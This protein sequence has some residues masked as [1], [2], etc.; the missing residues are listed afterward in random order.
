MAKTGSSAVASRL[1]W[2]RQD[3]HQIGRM[4]G[5]GSPTHRPAMSRLRCR[6]TSRFAGVTSG[7]TRHPADRQDRAARSRHCLRERSLVTTDYPGRIPH[8]AS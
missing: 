6:T 4:T 1:A 8:G 7:E 3:I 5:T 2:G